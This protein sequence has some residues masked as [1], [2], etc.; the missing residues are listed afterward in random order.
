MMILSDLDR[1]VFQVETSKS[2]WSAMHFQQQGLGERANWQEDKSDAL[3]FT[4][5]CGLKPLME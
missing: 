4:N 1:K 5:G 3:P 2:L